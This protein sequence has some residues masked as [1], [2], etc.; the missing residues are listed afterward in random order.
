MGQAVPH[1]IGRHV[2]AKARSDDTTPPAAPT[3]IDYLRL[4]EAQHTAELA[5]RV[6][7]SQLPDGPLPGQEQPPASAATP[8]PRTVKCRHDREAQIPLR[9][10][11]D[12]VRPRPGTADAAPPRRPRRSRRPDLLVHQRTRPGCGHRRSRRRQDRRDPRRPRRPR[13]QPAHH[14]LPRQ[15]R[16]RRPRPLRL[17]RHRPRR[18]APL[19]QGGADSADHGAARR[20]RT[21]TRPHHHPRP[22]R[23]P[24]PRRRP[25]SRNCGS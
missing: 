15:P 13:H 2:H 6:R 9:I 8:T 14:R 10:H 4:I 5:E 7:Y 23:S 1:R 12:P 16:R 20:R 11:Q 21:R 17:H 22:R 19:P 25:R 24:P 18:R 3:G